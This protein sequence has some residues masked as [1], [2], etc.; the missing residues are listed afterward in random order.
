MNKSFLETTTHEMNW[1]N[2]NHLNLVK[3][4]LLRDTQ[5]GHFHFKIDDNLYTEIETNQDVDKEINRLKNE[6]YNS[7]IIKNNNSIVGF[8]VIENNLRDKANLSIELYI[9]SI[10][11]SYKNRGIGIYILS[12]I[13]EQI[14]IQAVSHRIIFKARCRKNSK[15]MKNILE[16]QGFIKHTNYKS[17]NNELYTKE[18]I[19]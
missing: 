15:A 8:F 16:K 18:I 3:K 1:N 5:L 7:Y 6:H 4:L 9:I 12:L 17:T 14:K 11:E 10:L 2:P 19:S 13:E